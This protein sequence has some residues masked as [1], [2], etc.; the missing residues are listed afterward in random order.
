MK[1]IQKNKK[2][3]FNYFVNKSYEAGL[4]LKGSEVKCIR[5]YGI[6]IENSFA[7]AKN[8]ELFLINSIINI[9]EKFKNNFINVKQTRNIKLLLKKEEIKKIIFLKKKK[10]Y[11]LVPM[12]IYFKKD[13][14][15][16]EIGLCIGKKK[17][18]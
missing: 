7:I 17:M 6:I 13:K 1:I 14:I 8:G 16:A 11:T 4:V 2:V 18:K 5:L 12:K 10:K 3:L 9:P 15:K